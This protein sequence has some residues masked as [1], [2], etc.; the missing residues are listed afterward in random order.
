MRIFTGYIIPNLKLSV[1]LIL[2]L[3]ANL[4]A[5]IVIFDDEYDKCGSLDHVLSRASLMLLGD[6]WGYGY[7]SLQIDLDTWSM[8]PYA[9]IDSI[10]S[11]VQ[12]RTLWEITI[13]GPDSTA[14][15]VKRV[16]HIHARTHPNEVQSSWVTNEMIRILLSESI[17]AEQLRNSIIFHI[18]PMYNPDGVELEYSRENAN[19]IDIESNWYANNVEIEVQAL[20]SRYIEL[21]NSETPIDVALNMHSSSRGK[22]FFVC[23][24]S[25]GSS[26]Q[27]FEQEQ[28]V[29]ASVRSGFMNGIEPWNYM[30]TWVGSTPLKYPESWFWLNH[31]EA[32]MA[33][34]YED[35]YYDTTGPFDITATA[36]L[37]GIFHYLNLNLTNRTPADRVFSE[38][39]VLNQ[40]YP[41]PFNPTT[42]ISYVLTTPAEVTLTVYDI[43]GRI[44]S[45][46]IQSYKAAGLHNIHWNG[47][48]Q[49]GNPVS[50]GMY[51]CR[52]EVVDPATGRA[53]DRKT[54]KML[55]LQ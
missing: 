34:T 46:L 55:Y 13:T 14:I 22:R 17:L 49:S 37:D 43:T 16:V 7:D 18:V 41:N 31:Q 36:L 15:D 8:S 44:T 28:R 38:D 27:Y 29:I 26:P 6:H 2:M 20:R 9:S 11:S 33:L 5:Q 3:S 12:G 19:G 10:G 21:M 39:I 1:L 53:G 45:T 35:N 54:I 23:H 42:T 32:V 30:V 47:I 40:N 48:D 24:D 4:Q 50:T 51:F 25:S 52:L